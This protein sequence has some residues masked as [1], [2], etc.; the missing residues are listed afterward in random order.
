MIKLSMSTKTSSILGNDLFAK[1]NRAVEDYLKS[2][3]KSV[4]SSKRRDFDVL[5][6]NLANK[7]VRKYKYFIFC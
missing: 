1:S 3:N 2:S 5:E 6:L 4:K 7:Y